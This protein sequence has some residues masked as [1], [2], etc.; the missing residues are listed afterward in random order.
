MASLNKSPFNSNHNEKNVEKKNAKQFA[1]D[2][3]NSFD[4]SNEN[5][6]TCNSFVTPKK[7]PKNFH[8]RESCAWIF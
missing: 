5:R 1:Y 3:L 7:T 8:K 6:I 2:Y 4:R